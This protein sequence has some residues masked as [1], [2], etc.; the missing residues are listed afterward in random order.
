MFLS[1]LRDPMIYILLGAV[2]ISLF[3]KEIS[4]SI[5][6]LAVILLNAINRRMIQESKA[7]KSLEALKKTFKSDSAMV[8]SVTAFTCGDCLLLI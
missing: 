1:Q 7:E 5:I 3:L 6:I 8:R 2:V 4:D